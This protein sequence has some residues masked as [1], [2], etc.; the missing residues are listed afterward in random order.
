[1][2][3]E[4]LTILVGFHG[5]RLVFEDRR[6]PLPLLVTASLALAVF[7]G[8]NLLYLGSFPQ[9]RVLHQTWRIDWSLA[10]VSIVLAWLPVATIAA[11]RCVRDFRRLGRDEA[12]LGV[13]FAVGFGLSI[14]DRFISPVQ[15][16]HFTR[17]YVWMPLMLLGLPLL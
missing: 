4:I 14:H 12:F 1:M 9:H 13:A 6:Q 16:A 15:P 2:G 5:L 3:L 10:P 11:V 8:Y 7:L 17:G